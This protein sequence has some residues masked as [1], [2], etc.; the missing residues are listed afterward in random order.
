MTIHIK[1][2]V[3][4]QKLSKTRFTKLNMFGRYHRHQSKHYCSSYRHQLLQLLS[5]EHIEKHTRLLME[6]FVPETFSDARI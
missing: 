4:N 5:Y 6:Y 3:L 2:V 1:Q